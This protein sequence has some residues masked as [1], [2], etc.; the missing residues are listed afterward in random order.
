MITVDPRQVRIGAAPATKEDAIR[1]VGQLLVDSG[2]IQPGYIRS[3]FGRE[4]MANTYLGNG[5]VIPHGKPEDRDMIVKTG[6]AVLQV[7]AGVAWNSDSEVARLVVGIAARSDEHIE[8]LRRLTRVL[9]DAVQVAR[10]TSTGDVRDIVEALTGERPA[11]PAAAPADFAQGFDIAIPNSTGLHARPATA[12]VELARTFISEVRVRYGAESADAKS[13][14][15]LL[16]LGA[17]RD[18]VVHISAQGPDAAAALDA[19][20][21]A[22]TAGL[23]EGEHEEEPPPVSPAA[24]HGWTPRDATAMIIGI[25]ASDGLAVGVIAQHA[26]RVL[27]VTDEPG[28]D[29]KSVV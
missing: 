2:C 6:I 9:G 10:L 3:M 25:P 15:S 24:G 8:V 7:P 21:Q 17:G 29:R 16:Q 19:L 18:A 1:Q 14:I 23:G 4:A 12:L 13:L 11:A 20:R 27:V 26:R 22:I 28:L 5:I